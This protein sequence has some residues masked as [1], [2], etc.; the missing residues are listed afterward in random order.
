MTTPTIVCPGC[1]GEFADLAGPTHP[2]MESSP[3]CWAAFGE[4][5]AREY[6]DPSLLEVHRL[7]VD[8]YAAQHPG[9]PSP[10]SIQSVGLHLVRLLLQLERGYSAARAN[11]AMAALAKHKA[12]FVWLDPPPSPG[13]LTVANVA[14]N[15]KPEEHKA[16]VLA[17]AGAVLAAWSVHRPTIERWAAIV[18][19]P[20]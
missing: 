6:S 11:A 13:V 10:Q 3:G 2:Y 18:D 17:W 7:S 20:R 9:N 5:L 15:F 8:A 12:T 14:P 4:V 16:A 1:R 19:R